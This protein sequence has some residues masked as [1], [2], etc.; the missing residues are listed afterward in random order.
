MRQFV[1]IDL[2]R[3]RVPDGTTILTKVRYRGLAKNTHR[4]RVACGL[5]NLFIARRQLLP[6]RRTIRY[7]AAALNA[8]CSGCIGDMQVSAGSGSPTSS[9][10]HTRPSADLFRPS[11]STFD[12]FGPS[13]PTDMSANDIPPGND[14]R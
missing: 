12:A 7:G 2:G 14:C 4:A 8:R 5:A 11:L 10:H 13:T 6:I 1:G 3:E 9:S